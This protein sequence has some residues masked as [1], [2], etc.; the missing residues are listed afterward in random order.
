MQAVPLNATS[1]R[2]APLADEVAGI[3]ASVASGGQCILGPGVEGFEAAFARWCGVAHAVGVGNGTDALEIALKA[4]GV[5]PGDRVAMA[6]N[7]GMYAA[8][9]ALACGATPVFVDVLA[10]EATLDPALLEATLADGPPVRAVVA[11]HLYGRLARNDA[12]GDACRRHGAKLVEDC[13]QA[14]GARAADGRC[15]G[16]FGDAAAFSFYPTKNLGALGDGGA[17]ATSSDEVADRARALRQYGWQG[18]YNTVLRGGRNSRLDELQARIL[19]LQLPRLDGWNARRRDIAARYADGIRNPAIQVPA[20]GGS[21]DVVHLFVVHCERRD[22]LRAHLADAGIGSDVHYPVPDHRQPLLA[23]DHATVSLPV[24]DMLAVTALSLPCFPELT[25][26]E[27]SAVVDA[28][29][30]F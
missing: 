13:A 24:T 25:D 4:V 8:S 17:V 14:H 29:N 19:S 15:A 26:A 18:K 16:S 3:A 7:A 27:A 6:A 23:T 28:C 22:A 20:R 1:R 9:A 10:N 30:R 21:D 12:I 11:T 2:F 5:G